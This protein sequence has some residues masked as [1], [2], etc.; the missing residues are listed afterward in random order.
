M[1][2]KPQS[3]SNKT[4]VL[5]LLIATSLLTLMIGFSLGGRLGLLASF[6]ITV[7]FHITLLFF[8]KTKI[9]EDLGARRIFGQDPWGLIELVERFSD[10]LKVRSPSV[11]VCDSNQVFAFSINGDSSFTIESLIENASANSVICF[12]TGLLYRLKRSEVEVIIARQVTQAAYMNTLSRNISHVLAFSIIGLGNFLDHLW[13]LNIL[14]GFFKSKKN[15]RPFSSVLS[16]IAWLILKIPFSEQIYYTVDEMTA[17]L[18]NNRNCL[19]EA[20]WKLESYA[21]NQ[22]FNP[23]MGTHQYFAVNP[24][25]LREKNRFLLTHPKIDQRIQKLLGYF[26]L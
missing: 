15:Q 19:A 9:L 12:S 7:L 26:P 10:E 3:R 20:I 21:Q 18:T 11:Y 23:P 16:P 8:G 6:I 22:I 13:V 17:R 14:K 5:S 24:F 4:K 25:G 2:I 1:I